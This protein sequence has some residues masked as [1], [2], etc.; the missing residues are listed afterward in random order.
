M[1]AAGDYGGDMAEGNARDE[2]LDLLSAGPEIPDPLSPVSKVLMRLQSLGRAPLDDGVVARHLDMIKNEAANTTARAPL[3]WHRRGLVA[4]SYGLRLVVAVVALALLGSGAALAADGAVPGDALY[5]I[6]RFAETI[7]LD[8]GGATERLE[9]ARSLVERGDH[10]RAVELAQEAVEEL[11]A[12]SSDSAA[13]EAL[14]SAAARIME[15]RTA[16]SAGYQTTQPFRDQVAALVGVIAEEAED[17][18][19]DGAR[20]AETVRDF[21][22]TARAF[23]ETHSG[24]GESSR[25]PGLDPGRP[26]RGVDPPGRGATGPPATP[27]GRIP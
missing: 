26:G 18:V 27:A 23:A 19:I 16:S 2:L 20:I 8:A 5:G 25:S 10:N 7:G 4:V 12:D 22:E 3:T 15:I 9:E 17:G 6:D 11:A 21:S 14:E 24:D 13:V 1:S